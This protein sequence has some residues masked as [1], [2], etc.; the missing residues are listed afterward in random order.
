MEGRHL[1]LRAIV[2]MASWC[3][4][5]PR[6]AMRPVFATLLVGSVLASCLSGCLPHHHARH[7]HGGGTAVAFGAGMLLG[8]A[9]ASEAR[10][11]PE[12]PERPYR[13]YS[14]GY[15]SWPA[16]PRSSKDTP[17]QDEGGP[18]FDVSAARATFNGIDLT[19]CM[20]GGA[21]KYGHAK[22][23][24]APTGRVERVVIDDPPGLPPRAVACIGERLGG[25][26]L[27]P[28]R[29]EAVNVGTTFHLR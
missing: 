21:P 18:P 22:V 24:V 6:V 16:T 14:N 20:D 11:E 26:T 2:G 28:F 27:P 10:K 7:H 12:D 5:C 29:G 15:F 13:Y 1:D 19:G 9:I 25:A 8:A 23:T 3:T 17:R 4:C